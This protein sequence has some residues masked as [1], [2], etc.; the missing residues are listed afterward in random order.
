ML[1]LFGSNSKHPLADAKESRRILAELATHKPA[2]LVDEAAVWLESLAGLDDI[3]ASLRLTRIAEIAAVA[4]P[5]VR[6]FTRDYLGAPQ[7]AVQH[8]QVLNNWWMRLAEALQRCLTEAEGNQKTRNALKADWGALLTGL[9]VAHFGCL[10]CSQYR[11]HPVDGGRWAAMGHLYLQAVQ[12]KIVET[13]VEAFGR[14]EGSTTVAGEYLRILVF[15]ASSMGSLKTHEIGLAEHFI[16]HF[17]PYFSMSTESRPES[18]YWVDAGKPV[19]PARLAKPPVAS[20]TLR[21]FGMAGALP[22]IAEIRTRIL[23]SQAQPTDI[24]LGGQYSVATL[25]AVLDHLAGCWAAQL[26]VRSFPRHRVKSR[27]AASVGPISLR[28]LLSDSNLGQAHVESWQVEDVSQGGMSVRLPVS[29]TSWTKVGTFVGVQP[30]GGSNWL[31]GIIRRFAQEDETQGVA[32]IET[33]SKT[34]RAVTA[35]DGALKTELVLLDPLRDDTSVR[36]LL[37]PSNWDEG[38]TMQLFIDGQPWRLHPTDTIEVGDDWLVGNCI[39]ESLDP[40]RR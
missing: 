5:P 19:A 40:D 27:V 20:P 13:P 16:A 26:P 35:M 37:E 33:I 23:A 11:Y 25:L 3:S 28:A 1:G 36:I 15:H 18:A 8:W 24:N 38:E 29:R 32:G 22:A 10:R 31:A 17:L 4:M 39:A 7:Q 14:T 2:T 6:R 30:E 34:L 21:L 12:D 9:L